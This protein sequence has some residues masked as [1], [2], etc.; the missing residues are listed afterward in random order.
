MRISKREQMLLWT[1]INIS[2]LLLGVRIILPKVNQYYQ[3]SVEHLELREDQRLQADI[4]LLQ[5]KDLPSRLQDYK[6]ELEAVEA[7]Y[8]PKLDPEY[9][10]AWIM[11]ISKMQPI[12]VLDLSIEEV[13]M[14][15]EEGMI[16]VLPIELTLGG[17]EQSIIT[18][19]DNLL[20]DGRYVSIEE[21]S[22]EEGNGKVKIG[23]Y[24]TD[25]AQDELEHISF[26]APVGK[27]FLM[28][29]QEV[30]DEKNE[31]VK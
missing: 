28:S 10:E 13:R 27:S 25:K 29:A 19:I 20:N 15:D 9:I 14:Q 24:R 6:E 5:E 12:Q 22:L 30:K 11:S 7:L 2:V 31:E 3:T 26:N 1:L 21:L 18:F 23:I 8:F 17:E 16:E 4:L